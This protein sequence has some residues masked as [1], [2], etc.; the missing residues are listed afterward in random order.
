[1]NFLEGK[2]PL[3]V[4]PPHMKSCFIIIIIIIIFYIGLVFIPVLRCGDSYCMQVEGSSAHCYVAYGSLAMAAY[5]AL[6]L[7]YNSVLELAFGKQTISGQLLY[8]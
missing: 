5:W 2:R 4:A 1:M 3:P 6:I 8:A 7:L